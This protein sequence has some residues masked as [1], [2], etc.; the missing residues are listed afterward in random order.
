MPNFFNSAL[1]DHAIKL[2]FKI[3]RNTVPTALKLSDR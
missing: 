1:Q 2:I 3:Q